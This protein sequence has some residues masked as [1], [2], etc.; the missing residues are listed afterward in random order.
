MD[1]EKDLPAKPDFEAVYESYYGRIYRYCLT[2]LERREDAEDVTEDTFLAAMAAYEQY[3]PARS[4]LATWLTRIAHNQAVNLLRSAAY[5]RRGEM[6]EDWDAPDPNSPDP[7]DAW[8]DWEARERVRRLFM[9]L[10]AEEKQL[11]GLRYRMELS[12]KEI[13]ELLGLPV[14]TVNK[15]LQRL[16]AKCRIILCNMP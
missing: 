4:S 15:R 3:D 7:E 2:L 9:H 10:K 11:L 13:G 12:D 5:A 16:L 14:K 1:R 8:E 6:P